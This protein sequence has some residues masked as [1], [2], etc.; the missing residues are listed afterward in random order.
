MLTARRSHAGRWPK[1][2]FFEDPSESF[3][4]LG[5]AKNSLAGSGQSKNFTFSARRSELGKVNFGGPASEFFGT[6]E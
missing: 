6:G 1:S 2:E 5:A 4:R 3:G